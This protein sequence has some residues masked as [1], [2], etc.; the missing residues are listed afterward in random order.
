MRVRTQLERRGRAVRSTF[1]GIVLFPLIAGGQRGKRAPADWNFVGKPERTFGC[2]TRGCA[3]EDRTTR[4]GAGQKGGC[5]GRS[6][7]D[8]SRR[9]KWWTRCSG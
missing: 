1:C 2:I 8:F 4:D 7:E 5:R 3:T 6:L 9:W